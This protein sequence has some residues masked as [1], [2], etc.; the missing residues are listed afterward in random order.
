MKISLGQDVIQRNSFSKNAINILLKIIS[1]SIITWESILVMYQNTTYSS[2]SKKLFEEF[3]GGYKLILA[4]MINFGFFPDKVYGPENL[5]LYLMEK[6]IDLGISK[7][8]DDDIPSYIKMQKKT[9]NIFKSLVE[10][11]WNRTH[12]DICLRNCTDQIQI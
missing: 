1:S 2:Y 4:S 9:K 10:D 6:Y 7:C 5:F 12:S 8:I 3:R 11:R